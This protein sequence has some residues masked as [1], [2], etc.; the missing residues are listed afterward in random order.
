M[1]SPFNRARGIG[2][3]P[4]PRVRKRHHGVQETTA[5]IPSAME[6]AMEGEEQAITPE[7]Q[8]RWQRRT[9]SAFQHDELHIHGIEKIWRRN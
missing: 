3:R 9:T 8:G 5:R 6:I 4:T 7:I 2:T 1:R